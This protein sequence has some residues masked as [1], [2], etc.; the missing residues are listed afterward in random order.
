MSDLKK[1]A[2]SGTSRLHLRD[3]QDSP[4]YGDD[5]AG[6]PDTS[7]PMIVVLFG[8]GSREHARAVSKRDNSLAER[9]RQKGRNAQFSAEEKRQVQA[10]FL[11]DCTASWENVEYEGKK[12]SDM[13]VAIYCD[14]SIGFIADQVTRHLGDWANF[15]SAPAKS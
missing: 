9:V 3:A 6:K 5:A 1:H 7:K 4:M 10:D 14:V 8:P 15:T 11:A 2:V 13:S 12:D